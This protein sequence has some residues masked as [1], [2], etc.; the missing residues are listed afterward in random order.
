[1]SKSFQLLSLAAAAVLASS[2]ALAVD[3]A[4]TAHYA[5]IHGTLDIS[6]AAFTAVSSGTFSGNTARVTPG[7]DLTLSF[8]AALDFTNQAYCPA[9][10]IQ[11][12]LAWD[13]SAQAAGATPTQLNLF[14]GQIHADRN[15]GAKTW[16]VKAPT[17]PG[18][19]FIGGASSLQRNYVPVSGSLGVDNLASYKVTVAVPEPESVALML[20]GLLV[21]AFAVERKQ[22]HR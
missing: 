15:L 10:I 4:S 16:T 21:I 7:A 18:E 12:Y 2:S 1:M 22:A 17:T 3:V 9:C 13:A 8:N 5:N 6:N 20:A 14:S 11:E 19:Y